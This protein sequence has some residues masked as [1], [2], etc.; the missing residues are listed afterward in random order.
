MLTYHELYEKAAE[1][2]GKQEVERIVNYAF[3]NRGELGD[4][5]FST[6]IVSELT[7]LCKEDGALIVL[8]YSPPF[9]PSVSSTNDLHIQTTLKKIQRE[10]KEIYGIEVEEV[11]YFPGLSDLSYLQLEN[12]DIDDYTANMPLYQKG[13]SLPQGE[14]EALNVPVIN[15]GPLGKDAHKWTERL[16]VPFSFGVLPSLL[17]STIHALLEKN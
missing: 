12:Q 4:R 5:D 2:S 11:K 17:Q 14:K 6:K 8:F 1:R 15:V 9:Y 13:Y 10:A 7:T 3:A 16:H